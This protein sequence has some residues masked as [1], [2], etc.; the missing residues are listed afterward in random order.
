MH[1]TYCTATNRHFSFVTSK[2]RNCASF[3]CSSFLIHLPSLSVCI[4][5]K[6]II[7][8]VENTNYP[9]HGLAYLSNTGSSTW[10]MFVLQAIVSVSVLN[11]CYN[12]Y[13]DALTPTTSL[14]PPVWTWAIDITGRAEFT[15][16]SWTWN[17]ELPITWSIH[18]THCKMFVLSWF[19]SLFVFVT[20]K[21]F[22]STFDSQRRRKNV[23]NGQYQC[24]NI[25]KCTLHMQTKSL[26]NILSSFVGHFIC[27][28]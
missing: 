19:C 10:P 15:G 25:I 26:Y 5:L 2:H 1:L 21:D 20:F 18:Y 3:L 23:G 11:V 16:R 22:T 27:F 28:Y 4:D 17:T 13:D 7:I 12:N 8:N 9:Q 14:S 24:V 6:S